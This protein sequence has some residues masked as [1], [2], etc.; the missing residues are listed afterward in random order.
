MADT[1]PCIGSKISLI[2]T[3]DIRY[4][5]ILCTL[6]QEESTMEVTM[7]NEIYDLIVFRGKDLK[8][9][10]VLQGAQERPSTGPGAFG[11]L[12]SPDQGLGAS[13]YGAHSAA[14]AAQA[15]RP[16]IA[17]AGSIAATSGVPSA[18][19]ALSAGPALGGNVSAEEALRRAA[20][21]AAHGPGGFAYSSPAVGGGFPAAT[22][23][24]DG[25][26]RPAAA[27]KPPPSPMCLS[28]LRQVEQPWSRSI[29][30]R[31]RA[32]LR[33]RNLAADSAEHQVAIVEA[34]QRQA[35]A[36]AAALGGSSSAAPGS[37]YSRHG[38]HGLASVLDNPVLLGR[39]TP[40]DR[41]RYYNS[42][43]DARKA[44]ILR[45]CG[46][47]SGEG[48]LQYILQLEA[49][50]KDLKDQLQHKEAK[51][52][53]LI[54]QLHAK[55][56]EVKMLKDQLKEAKE[57]DLTDQMHAKK[58]SSSQ[59]RTWTQYI[60]ED[61]LWWHCEDE[62]NLYFFEDTPGMWIKDQEGWRHDETGES[63]C[64]H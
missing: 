50:V 13:A 4:E 37:G 29:D 42:K 17:T 38:A 18:G 57:K 3:S 52:K 31:Q 39:S 51:E 63:F 47:T 6:N 7:S 9:L 8:E 34:H 12:D 41:P 19:G 45:S 56:A 16:G 11:S 43:L 59:G 24:S 32:A 62:E 36:A 64:D 60:H 44:A 23:D 14:P 46:G 2:T 40:A 1:L 10:T 28:L 15:P 22:W 26:W 55:K 33:L 20:E 58:A 30:D 25:S 27:S 53:D 54:D 35:A 48:V 5:G 21:A 61:R 49:E